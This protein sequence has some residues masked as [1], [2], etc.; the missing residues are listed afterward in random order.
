MPTGHGFP[1]Q[2]NERWRELA[3]ALHERRA[4]FAFSLRDIYR[5]GGPSP[6][7]WARLEGPDRHDPRPPGAKTFGRIDYALRWKP[8]TAEAILRGDLSPE[9]AIQQE[10]Y[11]DTLS[12]GATNPLSPYATIN[13]FQRE[14][15]EFIE[16]VQQLGC[17][18]DDLKDQSDELLHSISEL[19]ITMLLEINGGPGRALSSQIVNLIRPALAAPEPPRDTVEHQRWAYRRWL[20]G[21]PV[22]E[23]EAVEFSKYWK[24]K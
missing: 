24:A 22:S 8:G 16:K 18:T 14:I 1:S 21:M 10:D 6:T 19:Y 17:I 9:E 23:S 5:R 15:I 20:A 13:E 12:P 7:T 11:A 2:D 4:N 3:K